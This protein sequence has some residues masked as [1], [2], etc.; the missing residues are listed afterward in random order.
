MSHVS[1]ARWR[2]SGAL[3]LLAGLALAPPIAL[4]ANAASSA[5]C[6]GGGFVISGLN[7]GSTVSTDGTTTIPASNLGTGF[8][9]EGRY[10]EFTVVSASF[11]VQDWTLTGVPNPLD[12][13]GNLR[14]VV[15]DSKTPD[16]RGLILTGDVTVER[17]GP[18]I[19]LSRQ[20]PGLTMKI[21][22]KDCA[23]G[24][25]FQMEIGRDDATATRVTHILADGVFYF[26]NPNFRAREGDVLAFKDTTVTVTPRINFANDSS[27]EF[28]GRD[29]PQ[30]ATRVQEPGCVNQ[31]A[32]RT[33]G[34]AT[35][36][37]CGAISRWDVAS[38]GR[39]GQVMG[40][41]AVE[42]APPATP[43]T[44]HVQARDRARGGSGALRR[45]CPEPSSGGLQPPFPAP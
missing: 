15:Y 24:G 23:N 13:T 41:D 1:K 31:I 7:D 10:V 3:I 43:C 44:Q 30:V 36:R 29:S 27:F 22:A 17:K 39:M 45:P 9:V 16:H 12:I 37:H 5:G 38:G 26:D 20:G 14:T 40:E 33:G 25:V 28:V 11:G 18:D 35:V 34:T 42:V 19:V 2:A 4:P 32:T 8:L 21:Q 6:E